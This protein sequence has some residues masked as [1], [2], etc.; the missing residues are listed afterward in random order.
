MHDIAD[1]I[2]NCK[3]F[4]LPPVP[5]QDDIDLA[6]SLVGNNCRRVVEDAP[7]QEFLQRIIFESYALVMSQQNKNLE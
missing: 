6:V 7:R 2:K 3:E 5:V 4:E 1:A